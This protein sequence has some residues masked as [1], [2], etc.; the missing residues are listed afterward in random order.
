MKFLKHVTCKA[1]TDYLNRKAIIFIYLYLP[2][3][4]VQIIGHREQMIVCDDKAQNDFYY[5][6]SFLSKWGR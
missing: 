4:R 3:D 1:C 6:V 5:R 2:S